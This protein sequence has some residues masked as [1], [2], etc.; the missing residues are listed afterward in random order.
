MSRD[1]AHES[2]QPISDVVRS[3]RQRLRMNTTEFARQLGVAQSVVSRYENGSRHPGWRPLAR[4]L[5][6][7]EG[8]ERRLVLKALSKIKGQPIGE[9]EAI[10]EGEKAV[11][12][13][14]FLR[15]AGKGTPEFRLGGFGEPPDEPVSLDDLPPNLRRFVVAASVIGHMG[16]EVDRSLASIVELW[17]H[18]GHRYPEAARYFRDAERFLRVGFESSPVFEDHPI[19]PQ[20]VGSSADAPFTPES[21]DKVPHPPPAKPPRKKS[22]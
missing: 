11:E 9:M 15:K 21:I 1:N 3:V 22:A 12:E 14:E 7:A 5:L 8:A 10:E 19:P 20:T 13:D 6:I 18:W 16:T 17:I 2:G 4:L